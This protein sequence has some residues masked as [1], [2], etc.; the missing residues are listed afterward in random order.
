[1]LVPRSIPMIFGITPSPLVGNVGAK[2]LEPH[3][4]KA[5]TTIKT[6]LIRILSSRQVPRPS[7]DRKSRSS[8]SSRRPAGKTPWPTRNRRARSLINVPST[9]GR[10]LPP[11]PDKGG[12]GS[13]LLESQDPSGSLLVSP[14]DHEDRRFSLRIQ[15]TPIPSGSGGM[16]RGRRGPHADRPH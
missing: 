1:L 6:F 9:T 11:G 12:P 16:T 4:N 5:K 2:P 3:F 14:A 15:R 10:G 13:F 8:A 7:Q